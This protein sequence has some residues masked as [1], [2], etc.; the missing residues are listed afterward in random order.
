MKL[1]RLGLNRLTQKT[2]MVSLLGL[3]TALFALSGCS[4]G[5]SRPAN[6]NSKSILKLRCAAPRAFDL[7]R[8]NSYRAQKLGP[9]SPYVVRTTMTQTTSINDS[10]LAADMKLR[11]ESSTVDSEPE[12]S[13]KSAQAM[14]TS[15]E[16][17]ILEKDCENLEARVKTPASENFMTLKIKAIKFHSIELEG[18]NGLTVVIEKD[19][20]DRIEKR[21]EHEIYKHYN[22]NGINKITATI[23]DP[24]LSETETLVTTIVQ[25]VV[26]ASSKDGGAQEGKN[27]SLKED[28]ISDDQGFKSL[29]PV[30]SEEDSVDFHEETLDPKIENPMSD[31]SNA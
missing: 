2:V 18:E 1:I 14:L 25:E 26:I 20:P 10:Q 16:L 29:P 13:E 7:Q 27:V 19:Y 6:F 11:G 24:G 30:D 3:I 31:E 12:I 22:D 4:R 9:D 28:R 23:T 21:R 17:M 5:H 15:S 8:E